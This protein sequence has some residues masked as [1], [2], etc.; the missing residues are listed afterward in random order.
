MT[1]Q[2]AYI[3]DQA[4]K[5]KLNRIFNLEVENL[6]LLK[7]IEELEAAIKMEQ[8]KNKIGEHEKT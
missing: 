5:D 3:S 4:N 7:R 2:Q 8:E 6:A 1:C